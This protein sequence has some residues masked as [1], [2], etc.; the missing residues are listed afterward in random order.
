MEEQSARVEDLRV[1]RRR[2]SG[3]TDLADGVA[4]DKD[5]G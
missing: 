4:V 5:V 2:Q 3:S 1:G